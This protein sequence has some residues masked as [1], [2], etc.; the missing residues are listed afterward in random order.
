MDPIQHLAAT[1]T[2]SMQLMDDLDRYFA[3]RDAR[4]ERRAMWRTRLMR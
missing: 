1:N 4:R 3:D 2:S